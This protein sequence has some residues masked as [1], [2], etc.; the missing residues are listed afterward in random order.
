MKPTG[1]QK[2]VESALSSLLASPHFKCHTQTNEQMENHCLEKIK[3]FQESAVALKIIN[4]LCF[5]SHS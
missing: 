3:C 5:Q 4:K 2:A 1:K